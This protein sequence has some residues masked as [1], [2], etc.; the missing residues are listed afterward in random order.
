HGCDIGLDLRIPSGPE[1]ADE[2]HHV[3]LRRP[4]RECGTRFGDLDVRPVVAVR[5]ADGGAD[6]DIRAAQDRTGTHDIRWPAADRGHVICRGELTTGVYEGI[7]EL[8]L[9]Q[10]MI[11][12]LGDVVVGQVL[13][14]QGHGAHLIYGRRV[15]RATRKPRLTRSSVPSKTRSSCSMMMSPS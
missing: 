3:Q 14:G 6:L 4:I 8:R 13:D 1:R 2:Q 10:R 15:S 9:E 5:E 11:D 12:G 7:V